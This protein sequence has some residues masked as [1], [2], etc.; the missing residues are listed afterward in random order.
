MG[1]RERVTGTR[2]RAAARVMTCLVDLP[3][4]NR[5]LLIIIHNELG[6]ATPSSVVSCAVTATGPIAESSRCWWLAWRAGGP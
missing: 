4:C 2:D 3:K 1:L 5:I 6:T